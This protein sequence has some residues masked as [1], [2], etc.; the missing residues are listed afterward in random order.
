MLKFFSKLLLVFLPITIFCQSENN[1][2]LFLKYNKYQNLYG[3]IVLKIKLL[4][5][6]E[7]GLK[8][9]MGTRNF[10]VILHGVCRI[11]VVE[12]TTIIGQIKDQIKSSS[13]GWIKQSTR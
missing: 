9:F 2:E 7:M 4:T 3:L 11:V 10:R 6:E 8:T 5:I 12:I 1:T 13:N